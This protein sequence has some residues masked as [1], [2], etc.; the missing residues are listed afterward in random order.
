MTTWY[1]HCLWCNGDF[2][3]ESVEIPPISV[4]DVCHSAYLFWALHPLKTVTSPYLELATVKADMRKALAF[5][6]HSPACRVVTY[7]PDCDCGL[8][9]LKQKYKE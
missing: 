2:T 5:A 6:N 3:H 1:T 4:C 7:E 9:D 8:Y